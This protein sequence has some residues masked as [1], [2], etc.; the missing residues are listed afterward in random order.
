MKSILTVAALGLTFAL[1]GCKSDD[2]NSTAAAPGAVSECSTDACC[3]SECDSAKTCPATGDAVA[4]GAVSE[5]SG[6]CPSKTEC[7]GK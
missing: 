1:V 7:S 2:A 5:K 4:P 3:P 6:C